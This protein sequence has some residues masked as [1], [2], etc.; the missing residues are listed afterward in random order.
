MYKTM[1][2]ALVLLTSVAWLHAQ[3]YPQSDAGQTPGQTT[4]GQT[5]EGCLQSS[6]G[7]YTLTATNGTTY[8][9]TG[10]TSKL[11]DHVGHEVQITGTTATAASSTTMGAASPPTLD[12]KSMK[13]ISKTCKSAMAK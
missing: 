13:H 8:Q 4:S 5:I 12:V 6:G 2:L 3:A 7:N 11:S 10:D 1:M 9:L